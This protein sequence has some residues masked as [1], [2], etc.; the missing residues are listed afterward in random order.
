[1][2]QNVLHAL[3]Q[4]IAFHEKALQ[5]YRLI[6]APYWQAPASCPSVQET[7]NTMAQWNSCPFV[8]AQH[9]DTARLQGAWAQLH[10]GDAL[11][12]PSDPALQE[13]WCLFHNG[14]FQQSA[15]AGLALG[16][17]GLVVTNKATAVYATYLETGEKERFDLYWQVARRA[18]AQAQVEPDNANAWYWQAYALGRYSQGI[19]VAKA[20]AQG[21]GHKVKTALERTIALAPR[22]AEAR[23]VLGAFHA[24]TIDKVGP[25][26]GNMAYG[27]KKDVGLQMFEEAL[28]INPRSILARVEYARALVMLE[29][30][31]RMAQAT[32]LYQQA[33]QSNPLDAAEQLDVALARTELQD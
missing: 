18:G 7:P 17:A 15:E 5:K 8:P 27:A 26:I 9:Y 22:H 14:Q 13:A 12:W 1:M 30:D 6:K 11:P 33:A 19:S 24:E 21:I 20:L 28:R 4:K 23:T 3:Q 10:A 25:L 29:G 32:S 31:K 2:L 16:A